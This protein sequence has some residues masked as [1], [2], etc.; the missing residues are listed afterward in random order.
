M[1]SLKKILIFLL[2]FALFGTATFGLFYGTLK[3]LGLCAIGKQG[4]RSFTMAAAGADGTDYV[5]ERMKDGFGLLAVNG[6]G[7]VFRHKKLNNLPDSYEPADL[8]VTSDGVVLLGLYNEE[9]TTEQSYELYAS[10]DGTNFSLLLQE[11]L[12]GQTAAQM[13][14][15]VIRSAVS[16]QD[17]SITFFIITGNTAEAYAYDA[18]L[19]QGVVS[20]GSFAV[21]QG[22]VAGAVTAIG[23]VISYADGRLNTAENAAL[24]TDTARCTALACTEN[25]CAAFDSAADKVRIFDGAS[26][27]DGVSLS[28]C[29]IDST[30][31]SSYTVDGAGGLLLILDGRSLVKVNADGSVTDLSASLYAGQWQSI[32]ALLGIL[33]AELI[34]AYGFYYLVCEANK[35]YFPIVARNFVILAVVGFWAVSVALYCFAFPA[36][37]DGV[38]SGT[39]SALRLYA[40]SC[41]TDVTAAAER[42]AMDNPDYRDAVVYRAIDQDGVILVTECSAK[43]GAMMRAAS[44]AAEY[45]EAAR[46]NRAFDSGDYAI[47][48][49]ENSGEWYCAY[50]R[51]EDG[52]V[53]AIRVNGNAAEQ[54]IAANMKLIA[55]SVYG[56]AALLAA[57]AL[58]GFA[59]AAHAAKRIRRGIDILALGNEEVT[60]VQNSGDEFSALASAFNDMAGALE[61]GTAKEDERSEAYMRFVPRQLLKLLGATGIVGVDKSTSA[62]LPLA[63]MVVRFRFPEDVYLSDDK[64]LF[65]NIN[66]VFERVDSVV[67]RGDGA[68]YNF[69]YDGFDAVFESAPAAVSAAVQLR[70]EVL[71]LNAERVSAGEPQVE[72]R[73]ALEYGQAM[74]GVVGDESRVVPT[75][76]SVCLSTARAL[77][78]L[79]FELGANIL[80]T[81]AVADIAEEYRL[82]YIGKRREGDA[83]IRVYEVTDGDEYAV[84]LEKESMRER[85]A[86]GVYTLYSR[87]F[88]AAKRIFMD[89]ARR[90]AEDGVARHYL[91]LADRYEKQAPDEVSL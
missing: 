23:N 8:S 33:A 66:S 63:M 21:E 65:E 47:A 39:L 10:A 91:Y 58:L 55:V 81:A 72:L 64:M 68:I 14:E 13:R 52:T 12:N 36:Y 15:S 20:K 18:S 5:L 7:R 16:E 76:A 9:K 1:R 11:M 32:L 3:D 67:S 70:Q 2:F 24:V 90:E 61:K 88:A 74:L 29:G 38:R 46:L 31:V 19:G 85:F 35:I 4:D 79:A 44:A 22:A 89:I 6:E 45:G 25:G 26:S 86:D 78:D 37:S 57:I 34:V 42:L 40:G 73:V 69:T 59:A 28:E 84:R 62:A 50:T 56:A 60:V 27:V 53:T 82:R 30:A 49:Q 41:G 80:C 43:S 48:S 77:A 87:D 17:G 54:K 75:V 51:S 71:N 83:M